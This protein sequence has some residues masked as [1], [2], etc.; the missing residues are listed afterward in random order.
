MPEAAMN[1]NDL[2]ELSE[3]KI[4]LSRQILGVKSVSVSKGESK[5]TN[6]DFRPGVL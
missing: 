2:A 4:R 5:L 3:N 1:E 6:G